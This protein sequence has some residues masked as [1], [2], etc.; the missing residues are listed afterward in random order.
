MENKAPGNS[1]KGYDKSFKQ[2]NF[3]KSVTVIDFKESITKLYDL[4][5]HKNENLYDCTVSKTNS[6]QL[7]LDNSTIPESDSGTSVNHQ[8]PS[9]NPSSFSFDKTNVDKTTNECNPRSGL[10]KVNAQ[11]IPKVVISSKLQVGSQRGD[12]KVKTKD[13]KT[14][15]IA[16]KENDDNPLKAI[17]HILHEFESIQK[18]KLNKKYAK[19]KNNS[20]SNFKENAIHISNT[21]YTTMPNFDAK[22]HQSI[23]SPNAN[24]TLNKVVKEKMPSFLLTSKFDNVNV[25]HSDNF[26]RNHITTIIEEDKEARG[27][28]V[29]GPPKTNYSRIN[30]LAQPRRSYAEETQRKYGRNYLTDRLQRL[31]SSPKPTQNIFPDVHSKRIKTKIHS[32]RKTSLPSKFNGR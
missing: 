11:I 2:I 13:R 10:T 31:A 27:E 19:L 30:A 9:S 26:K 25:K 20:T 23:F 29:R 18:T 17:S 4:I 3:K 15:N 6:K 1:P 12:I 8:F 5:K 7:Y 22:K 28:A 24:R 16:N 21:S 14:I 32:E